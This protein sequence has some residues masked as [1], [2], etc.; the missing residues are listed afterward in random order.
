MLCGWSSNQKKAGTSRVVFLIEVLGF[1]GGKEEEEGR[2][3]LGRREAGT[4]SI[5]IFKSKRIA[6][7]TED[8]AACAACST[9]C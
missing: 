5:L 9:N 3:K 4:K 7:V 8:F 6:A 2:G 1:P